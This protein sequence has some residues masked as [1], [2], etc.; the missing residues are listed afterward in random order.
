MSAPIA[1]ALVTTRAAG[2][3]QPGKSIALTTPTPVA[4]DSTPS[5]THR[6]FKPKTEVEIQD[7]FLKPQIQ[8]SVNDLVFDDGV[9]KFNS[10]KVV[11]NRGKE[12]T[13]R[14]IT[15]EGTEKKFM[16]IPVVSVV[17]SAFSG[18]NRHAQSPKKPELDR[19]FKELNL[20]DPVALLRSNT[21][22]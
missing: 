3:K 8:N 13:E 14:L 1:R 21:E 16:N 2:M 5:L 15:T 10:P 11:K 12:T 7:S 9:S 18:K 4:T 17:L 19:N 6:L 20:L 22:F